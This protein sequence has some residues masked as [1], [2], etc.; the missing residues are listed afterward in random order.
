MVLL[1]TYI[2]KENYYPSIKNALIQPK[3]FNDHDIFDDIIGERVSATT[4]EITTAPASV[5]ANSRKREP[6]SPPCNPMGTRFWTK[7]C[8]ELPIDEA[9][10][11]SN[12]SQL[13]VVYPWKL[14]RNL[15]AASWMTS[16]KSC[17]CRSLNSLSATWLTAMQK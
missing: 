15:P 9:P 10:M 3:I 11:P 12:I 7:P 2:E 8:G 13:S 4:P 1:V 16:S 6:V 5:K 17:Y 14:R